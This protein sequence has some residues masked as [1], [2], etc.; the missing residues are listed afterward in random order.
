MF[1]QMQRIREQAQVS[2][3]WG[4]HPRLRGSRGRL[5]C[6]VVETVTGEV[7]SAQRREGAGPGPRV[8]PAHT[9]STLFLP[10]KLPNQSSGQV[11]WLA[12]LCLEDLE[13]KGSRGMHPALVPGC[14]EDL[15]PRG[16][17][18]PSEAGKC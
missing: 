12:G 10:Q 4:E 16:D 15:C 17:D 9:T 7:Q 8:L 3:Y 6:C 1:G 2:V 18:R 11:G 5:S 13:C 14:R